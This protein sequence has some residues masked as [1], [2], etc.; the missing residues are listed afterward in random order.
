LRQAVA[1]VSAGNRRG[2]IALTIFLL[3]LCITFAVAYAGTGEIGPFLVNS[4]SA[5]FTPPDPRSFQGKPSV[6][7]LP[8][9]DIVIGFHM[10]D[11]NPSLQE[12]NGCRVFD[13]SGN[14]ITN[15]FKNTADYPSGGDW[16]NPGVV[17]GLDNTHFAFIYLKADGTTGF[18]YRIGGRV[19]TWSGSTIIEGSE[20]ILVNEPNTVDNLD[21]SVASLG[22][23]NFILTYSHNVAATPG[24]NYTSAFVEGMTFHGDPATSTLSVITG[25][26]QL[27]QHT[28]VGLNP[29][30]VAA[31]GTAVTVGW[32]QNLSGGG[33]NV[34]GYG[35]NVDATGHIPA[36]TLGDIVL[37]NGLNS[38]HSQAILTS[39]N[40]LVLYV[41]SSPF[42]LLGKIYGPGFTGSPSPFQVN[43]NAAPFSVAWARAQSLLGGGFLVSWAD[44]VSATQSDLHARLY[45]SSNNPRTNEFTVES[46]ANNDLFDLQMIRRPGA[47]GFATATITVGSIGDPPVVTNATTNEDTQT[48]SGLVIT[49]NAADGVDITVFKIT[50]I[51]NGSLFQNNGTTQ[52]NNGDFITIAQGNAGLKFTPSANLY[53]NVSTFSFAVAAAQNNT[54]A[55]LGNPSTATITVNPIADTPS[56]ANSTTAIN[57]QTTSGLVISRNAADSTEVTHFK[58]T[59]ITNGTLFQNDGTTPI[60]NNDFITFA[61]GNAGLKFTPGNNLTDPTVF[62]FDVQASLDNTNGGLGG[63]TAHATINVNCTSP[64]V[65]TST[66]DDGSAGTLRYAVLN[67]CPGGTV[68]F[69]LPAGP[70]TITLASSLTI[71]KDATITG[72]TSQ[73]V[74]INGNGNRVLTITSGNVSISNLTVSGG[75]AGAGDGGGLL[76]SS[77]GTITLTGM[78][79]TGNTAVNGGGIAGTAGTI[80][81][82]NS[83]ISGNTSIASGGG[84]FNQAGTLNLTNVTVSNNRANSDN[85]GAETGGGLFRTAGTV[86]LKNTIVAGNF[87]A[88]GTTSDDV[89][90]AVNAASLSNLVGDGTNLTGITNGVNGN[91]VGTSGSPL[92]ARLGALSDNGGPTMTQALLAGSPALDAGDNTT[93]NNAG[94]TTDQRAGLFGRIRDAASD[95]DTTQTVDVGAFEADPSIEDIADKATS[96]DTALPLFIFRVGDSATAFDSITAT[97]S[98]TTLVPNAN[99]TVGADTASTR[100]LSISPA[101]NQSGSTTITVTVTKTIGGTAV[102]MSDTFVLTVGTVPD[103]PSVTNATTNEDTQSTSG[104]AITKNVADGAEV[105]NFKITNI[106]GGTLFKNDGTTVIANNGF[107][108]VAEGG[109]GLKFAP[110]ANSIVNGSFQVQSSTDAVGTVL[111]AGAATATITVVPVADTPSATN[112]TTNEDVQTTSGLVISRNAVDGAEVTHFKISGITNGT[113]FKNDGTT[114]ITNNSFITFAEG[115]A[116]LKFTPAANLFSPGTTFSFQVQ[117]ATSSGGAGLSAGT[118]TAT[119]TVNTLADTPS[120]TNATTLED[121]QTTSGLVVSRNA[122]DGAEVTN[123]KITGI[124]G[125]TLFQSNGT[126]Q[127]N[128]NDFIT[129]AQGAAGL[130]FTPAADSNANGSF[131]VQASLNNTNAGLGGGLATATITVTPVNDAPT[132][133]ALGNVTINEDA[134]LQ[135][136]NLSGISAGGGETQTLVITA[137]SNNASV[138][139]NPTV[140]YTSPSATGSLGFTPVANANGST[141]IT[142]TLK[143]DGGTAN[144]GV[145]NVVR[146]FT[147]TVNSVNSVPSFIKGADQTIAENSGAQTV[148]NWAT[149]VSAGPSD[150]SGQTLTFQV[151][152]NTNAALFQRGPGHQLGRN[153][154]LHAGQ[155]CHGHGPDHCGPQGQWRH[156]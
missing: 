65:V 130:K 61:V 115:N 45:D 75:N 15:E 89:S 133:N 94:L 19:L 108:T 68:S 70:Q 5:V 63:G 52:I 92:N 93:A 88:A 143:D 72:P 122:A 119:I 26:T 134:G 64:Q 20:F 43:T 110:A 121:T 79:F 85:S 32:S 16:T 3:L 13:P 48:A 81:I 138:V 145:D 152:N 42:N 1:R 17:V 14:P 69:N 74:T 44:P 123:F 156:A 47:G 49:K 147:V 125:G 126:T 101:A 114:A 62:G 67:L 150:E 2:L 12:Y 100:T 139:P 132:L 41:T 9:G 21:L 58:I 154:D 111:S 37:D 97:S 8:N 33:T 38:F 103:T 50:N 31:K 141:L 117:A 57:T 109:A 95:A 35:F 82:L 56:V 102:S 29:T 87:R 124:T 54:G 39:G 22:S 149:S 131:Q 40:I 107:I 25:P 113:L 23:N 84:I 77:S 18:D 146:S 6:A 148:N 80:N 136:V 153:V 59:N 34:Y 30:T 4:T 36:L 104:L 76:N 53:S 140:N 7:T 142:V 105:T 78:L 129:L 86:T 151:T 83:T 73:S 144:G 91:Q 120:V 28:A 137:T 155:Q 55:G 46:V 96:E 51:T 128:N 71:N 98:N 90:G 66:L 118:A 116:G 11:T 112:A 99:I 24:T 106:V 127:I 27:G 60:N 10:Y 135:T